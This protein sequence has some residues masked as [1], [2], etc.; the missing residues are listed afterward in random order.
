[1]LLRHKMYKVSVSQESILLIFSV[2]WEYL[3]KV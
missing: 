1:M 2:K 3:T